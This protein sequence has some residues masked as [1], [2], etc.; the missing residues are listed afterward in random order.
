MRVGTPSRLA[1]STHSCGI[2]TGYATSAITG[3][4]RTNI[5]AAV[6]SR[7]SSRL[8]KVADSHAPIL[9]SRASSSEQ[10]QRGEDVKVHRN[11]VYLTTHAGISACISMPDHRN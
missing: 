11:C 6:I 10:K 7:I 3:V 5:T 4:L 9:V 2:E 8:H 1:S